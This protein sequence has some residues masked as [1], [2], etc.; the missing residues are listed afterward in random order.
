MPALVCVHGLSASSRWWAQVAFRMEHTGP[1]ILLDV[2]RSLSPSE[3]ANW[4]AAQLEALE[5]PVDL[6]GH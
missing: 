1:V 6:A 4:L 3:A 2:P 5:A